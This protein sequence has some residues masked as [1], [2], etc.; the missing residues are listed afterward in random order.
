M[1][2]DNY[3]SKKHA[4]K[5]A[6]YPVDLIYTLAPQDKERNITLLDFQG[7]ITIYQ[8]TGANEFSHGE[9]IYTQKDGELGRYT[10]SVKIPENERRI[11]ILVRGTGLTRHGDKPSFSL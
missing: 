11:L 5:A 1:I 9:E 10:L 7:S 8:I 3:L 4:P 2:R 6:D